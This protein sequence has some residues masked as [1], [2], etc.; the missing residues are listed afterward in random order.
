M[1][2]YC[3][4][5]VTPLDIEYGPNSPSRVIVH[6]SQHSLWLVQGLETQQ[7]EWVDFDGGGLATVYERLQTGNSK[8]WMDDWGNDHFK[9]SHSEQP[10]YE[11]Y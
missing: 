9:W 7:S 3:V 8:L 11:K 2:K 10:L 6:C 1:I 5:L 4:T